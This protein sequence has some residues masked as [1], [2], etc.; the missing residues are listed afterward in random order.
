VSV[1]VYNTLPAFQII[2]RL[3]FSRYVP[4]VMYLEKSKRQII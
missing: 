4:F 3:G 2:C 1:Q